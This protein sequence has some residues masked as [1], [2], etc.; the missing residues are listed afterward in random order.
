[1]VFIDENGG[2][3]GIRLRERQKRGSSG[4]SDIKL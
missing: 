3:P 1:M 2:D 4:E